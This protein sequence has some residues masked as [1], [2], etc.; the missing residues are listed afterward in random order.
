M[1]S[2]GCV[3]RHGHHKLYPVH[4]EYVARTVDSKRGSVPC[5]YMIESSPMHLEIVYTLKVFGKAI[6][7]SGIGFLDRISRVNA[8]RVLS[9]VA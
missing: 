5:H 8:S 7:R 1:A 3:M 4:S 6:D 9:I 2:G